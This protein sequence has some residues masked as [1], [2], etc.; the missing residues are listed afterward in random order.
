MH[1]GDEGDGQ[2]GPAVAGDQDVV[3]L[4]ERH[5]GLDDDAANAR[6][7]VVGEVPMQLLDPGV[8]RERE[9][10]LRFPHVIR[11]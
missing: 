9:R 2:R 10:D 3:G 11:P 7:A 4:L 1:V 8:G 5:A 6:A